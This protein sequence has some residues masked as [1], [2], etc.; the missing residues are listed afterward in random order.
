VITVGYSV[1][2]SW[3]N[4]MVLSVRHPMRH[5][6]EFT[7]NYTLSKAMDGGQVSGSN[8]TFAGTDDP[9]DPYNLKL[10][11]GASELDTRNRFVANLV[12][13]PTIGSLQS[14]AAKF[15]VNGWALSTIV[16]ESNGHPQQANISGTPT[17]L[18]GGLT[19]G[20]SYNAGTAAGRAGWLP[21][22]PYVAPG[23]HNVDF[24]LGRQFSLGERVKLTLLGET[25]NIFNH[26]NIASVNTTAFTYLAAGS[27]T[28]VAGSSIKCPG[29]NA[30]MVPSPTYFTPTATSSLLFGP[31]QIQISGKLTF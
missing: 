29:P 12:W 17:P 7:A 31:R 11:N 27:S 8:G 28:T 5:G 14:K 24:R 2:N 15:I 3:Y 4:S 25:F 19:A 6:L 23:F 1:V 18:D 22:D 9:L 21:R 16:T 30:C 20:V 13:M 10:E 26:M